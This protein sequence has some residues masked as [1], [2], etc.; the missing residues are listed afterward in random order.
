MPAA[1]ELFFKDQPMTLAQWPNA[2]FEKIAGTPDAARDEHGGTLGKLAAGFNYEGDRPQRWA[3]TN[4]IWI[5]G[6]WAYDWANSYEHVASIDTQKRLIKTD[7]P[8]GNYGFRTGQ[9]FYFLNILEELDE[10][11]EWYLDRKTGCPL[12]LA[13]RSPGQ[14]RRDGLAGRKPA[15]PHEQ[16][17]PRS[18]SWA[19]PRMRP[20]RCGADQGRQRQPWSPTARSAT[21]ATGP[22]RSTAAQAMAS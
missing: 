8:H 20:S 18:D 4:D 21:W 14:R 7:P 2:G 13:P 3:D 17:L 9:R 22:S 5:H 15:P 19:D 10:P 11:G 6:Y 1:L 12:L 16:R